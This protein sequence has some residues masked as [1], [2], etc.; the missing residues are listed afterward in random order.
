VN[1]TSFFRAKLKEKAREDR[2]YIELIDSEEL[3]Q[4]LT[5]NAESFL[6]ANFDFLLEKTLLEWGD[7]E[8]DIELTQDLPEAGEDSGIDEADILSQMMQYSP[9]GL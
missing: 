4:L 7:A 1:I 3:L 9:D 6:D 5:D 8:P 2:E